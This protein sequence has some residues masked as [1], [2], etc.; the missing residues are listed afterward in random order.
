[1]CGSSNLGGVERKI[2]AAESGLDGDLPNTGGAEQHLGVA[3]FDRGPRFRVKAAWPGERPQQHVR[4]EQHAHHRPSKTAITS[5]GNG[6]SKSSGTCSFP[7]NTPSRRL[8]GRSL[9]GPKRAKGLPAL[10][11]MI[12][13]PA[14]AASTKRDNW[15]LAA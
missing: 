9:R 3:A 1:E 5:S 11:I 15:V 14:A 13:S 6:A 10:A 12:S 4:V 8:R 7:A 2:A